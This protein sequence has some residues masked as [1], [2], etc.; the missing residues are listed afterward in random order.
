MPSPLVITSELHSVVIV[1]SSSPSPW[2]IDPER[3]QELSDTTSPGVTPWSDEYTSTVIRTS[4]SPTPWS[5]D[6]ERT[7]GL[8]P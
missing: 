6:P 7:Q 4:S 2:S 5:I 1:S 8:N 3:T